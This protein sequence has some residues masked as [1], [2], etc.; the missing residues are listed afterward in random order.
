MHLS[1]AK[2]EIGFDIISRSDGVNVTSCQHR[3]ALKSVTASN[4]TF[5][6][7]TIDFSNDA[8][9]AV[10]LDAQYKRKTALEEIQSWFA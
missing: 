6:Q 5:V 10:I 9:A 4:S 2:R 7:W 3:V 8:D 1:D